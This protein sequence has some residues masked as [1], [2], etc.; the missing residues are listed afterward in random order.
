MSLDPSTLIVLITVGISIW[1]FQDRRILSNLILSPYAVVH[2]KQWYRLITHAFIHADWMHLLFNMIALWSFGKAVIVY[3][4]AISPVA[5]LH[6]FVLYFVGI[7]IAS[8][9]DLVKQKDNLQF[10]SLGASGAVS[11][12]IFTAIFF[13]PWS[14]ILIFFIPC[15]AILFG[16]AYI[17]YSS[18]MGRREGERVNHNVHLYGALFGLIYPLL[19]NPKSLQIFL[20]NLSHPHFFN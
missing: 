12:I 11:A 18:Y 15:P 19:V 2:Q 4:E 10:L 16:V 14:T 17:L 3:L 20:Y 1:A 6:F 13:N 8:I 7:V 9:H 5:N